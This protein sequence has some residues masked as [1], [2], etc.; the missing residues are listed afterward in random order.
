MKGTI[1]C[2]GDSNTYGYDPRS[3]TGGRYPENVRWTGILQEKSGWSIKNHGVNGRCIPHNPSQIHFFCEQMKDWCKMNG[4]VK[5]WVMLGTNDLLTEAGF[6][7]EDTGLRMKKFLQV[8]V[9][10]IKISNREMEVRLI[11]PPPVKRGA[12][13]DEERIYREAEKLDQVYRKAAGELNIDFTGTAAWQ[14]PVA[15]DGV[16]FSEDGHRK[17]ADR[18]LKIL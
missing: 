5:I 17:F 9:E 11:S 6:T 4:P 16:H 1:I 14:I 7:A 8:L 12:W 2:Y 13:V 15:Y 18:L 3:L 10:Q